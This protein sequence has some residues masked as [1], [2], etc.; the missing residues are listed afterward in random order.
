MSAR[1]SAW[2]ARWSIVL[3]LL[4]AEGVIA[5]GFGA[6]LPILSIFYTEHGVGLAELGIVVAA[7]PAARLVGEPL[8]GRLADHVSRKWMMVVALVVSSFAVT[9][10]VAVSGTAAFIVLR[11]IAGL[12]AAAYDPGC[13][14]HPMDANPPERQG[15]MFV[16]RSAAQMGGF[17]VGPA[18]GG[19]AA[20]VTGNPSIVFVFG[21]AYLLS[22]LVVAIRVADLSREQARALAMRGADAVEVAKADDTGSEAVDGA[23]AGTADAEADDAP[24]PTRLLNRLL[25]VALVVNVGAYLAGGAYEVIWSVYMTSLGA[26]VA[27][28]GVSFFTFSPSRCCCRRSR[29]AMSTGMAATSSWSSAARAWASAA[30]C[31]CSCRGARGGWW[32]SGWGSWR[33]AAAI[34]SPSMYMLLRAAPPGRSSTAQGLFGAAGTTGNHRRVGGHGLPR[35][36]RPSA[37]VHRHGRFHGDPAGDLGAARRA[38]AL[39]RPPAASHPGRGDGRARGAFG[40]SGATW[41]NAVAAGS[42][43]PPTVLVLGGFITSPPMYRPP[44][45]D[46]ARGAADVV[47][48]NA[49]TMDRAARRGARARADLTRPG[50]ALLEAS[51]RTGRSRSARPC[52]SSGTAG[53]VS[54]RLLTSREPFAAGGSMRPGASAP[55]SRSTPH[56]VAELGSRPPKDGRRERAV[57]QRARPGR[58]GRRAWGT[59]RRL[60]APPAWAA[61]RHARRAADVARV[62]RHARHRRSRHRGR[63]A[64]LP[65]AALLLGVEQLVFD[66]AAHGQGIGRDWYGSPRFL[67]QWWPRALEASAGALRARS[68]SR[69]HLSADDEVA[70]ERGRTAIPTARTGSMGATPSRPKWSRTT[71]VSSAGP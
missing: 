41:R 21:L 36:H 55:S 22:A 28:I 29:A 37:A 64:D 67:D 20:A 65:S 32:W 5:L 58:P 51:E 59:P 12:G 63:R 34:A 50:R 11:L 9:L 47:V 30:C 71:P 26:N 60:V 14:R 56:M 23:A 38:R 3:P 15:E 19:I 7:W 66:D 69:I 57:R 17:M 70:L 1:L 68:A 6:I 54:A 25:I 43:P 33:I 10:P 39:R 53:G 52:S 49:W 13:P 4:A 31:T 42:A 48:G 44:W 45:R 8:F 18:V 35:R 2:L 27:L 40:V 24:H 46:S 16:R 61:P 62:Q